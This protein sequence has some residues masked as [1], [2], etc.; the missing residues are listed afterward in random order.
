MRAMNPVGKSDNQIVTTYLVVKGI[1]EIGTLFDS[2]TE[3]EAYLARL[4]L[5]GKISQFNCPELFLKN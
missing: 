4:I 3:A 2:L 1:L 5:S